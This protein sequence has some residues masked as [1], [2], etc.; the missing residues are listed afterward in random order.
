MRASPRERLEARVRA[1]NKAHEIAN[2]L[3]RQFVEALRPW[4]GKQVMKQTGLLAK[5]EKILPE[6]PNTHIVRVYRHS[7]SSYSLAWTVHVWE[8]Y[9]GGDGG[10][11]Y[12][13][14]FYVGTL[15]GLDLKEIDEREP[16]Y[17]TN[18]TA[19][20]IERKRADLTAAKNKV[21][22]AQGALHPFP[23]HDNF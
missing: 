15:A 12:E 13:V 5:V 23:E 1:T 16:N 17:R 18:F 6:T 21:S 20:E 22:E 7:L 14:T 3:R 4:V 2:Q 9:A 19:D 11:Y 8:G 10:V